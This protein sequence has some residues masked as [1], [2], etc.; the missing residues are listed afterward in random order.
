MYLMDA[1]TRP[2]RPNITDTRPNLY[3]VWTEKGDLIA[4]AAKITRD[5][6]YWFAGSAHG[7]VT[8][9]YTLVQ[10]GTRFTHWDYGLC[11]VEKINR[12]TIRLALI[13]QASDAKMG[14]RVL[15]V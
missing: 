12:K 11:E 4:Y 14:E 15:Y 6:R 10:A 2:T 7:P 9:H 8:G 13:D 5:G 1:N 3:Q